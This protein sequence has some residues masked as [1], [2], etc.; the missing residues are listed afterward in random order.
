MYDNSYRYF[1]T[2]MITGPL[3]DCCQ[4]SSMRFTKFK[5]LNVS[6]LVLQLSL[7]NALKPCVKSRMKM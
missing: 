1:I 6:R 7:P 4:T 2:Y 3:N 5:I